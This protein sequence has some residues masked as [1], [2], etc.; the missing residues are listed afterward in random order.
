MNNLV[1]SEEHAEIIEALKKE[2][3]ELKEETGNTMSLEELRAISDTNFGG[4]VSGK[5]SKL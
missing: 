4:H 1:N 2:L 3:Y 5:K